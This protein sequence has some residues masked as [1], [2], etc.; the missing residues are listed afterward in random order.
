VALEQAL[1][2][3]RSFTLDYVGSSGKRLLVGQFVNPENVNAAFSQGNGAYIITNGCWSNYNSLQA[4]FDQKLAHGFQ[5][6]A[7]LTWS[8]SIDNRSTSFI[9][10]QPL[11]K[12][13]SDFDLRENFQ[14]A[15]T[16]NTT[17]PAENRTL[18]RLTGG[19][20][21]DL[22]AFSRSAE[23]VDIYGR[24]F[25]A[26]DGTEEYARPNVL[27]G[28]PLYAY[29][30]HSSIPGG[31]QFNFAAFQAVTG[32][33]GNA[34]RNF[35]RGFPATEL[36]TAVRRS[37]PIGAGAHLEFRAEAFNL[38]NHPIFGS[39]YNNLLY[40]PSQFGLAYNT[41]NVALA[42]QSALY[43]QGGPRSLQLALKV[44]F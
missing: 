14:L 16:Y 10:F 35:L 44:L 18:R 36:D 32:A 22:R 2:A 25:V 40:G 37:F 9:S 5:L 13:D 7:S 6:L 3:S 19:W 28:V 39:I 23:P 38:L 17:S 1:G 42:N 41:L 33:Q 20:A 30:P 21:F 26:P 8:H 31:K 4:Q 11:L 12:A 27:P 15:A 34:P 43:E 29:G 24:A